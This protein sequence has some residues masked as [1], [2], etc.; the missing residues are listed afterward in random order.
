MGPLLLPPN[1][2]ESNMRILQENTHW[3]YQKP[4]AEMLFAANSNQSPF[5]FTSSAA[6]SQ[7]ERK[8]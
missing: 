2:L 5:E 3:I 7:N 1:E 6:H 4:S 8:E